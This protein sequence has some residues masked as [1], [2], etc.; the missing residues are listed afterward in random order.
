MRGFDMGMDGSVVIELKLERSRFDRDLRQVE[1]LAPSLQ[2]G[3]KLDAAKFKTDLEALQKNRINLSASVEI[4]TASFAQQVKKLSQSILPIKVDLAPNVDDFQEKLRR[5]SR[6]SPINVEIKADKAAVASEFEQIGKHAASGFAQGF[7]GS[8]NAAESAIDSLVNSVKTQLGIQSPSRVFR[9]IGKYAIEGLMQGLDSVDESKIKGV[10]NEIEGYFKASKI[11][12]EVGLKADTS[13]LSDAIDALTEVKVNLKVDSSELDEVTS[14]IA[15]EVKTK[16]EATVTVQGN[17]ST[18]AAGFESAIAKGMQ[19]ALAQ[20]NKGAKQDGMSQRFVD[21][22]LS[23]INAFYEGLKTVAKGALEKI[24]ASFSQSFGDS[25]SKGLSKDFGGVIQAA[26]A[27][28]GESFGFLGKEITGRTKYKGALSQEAPKTF[29][30]L[31]QGLKPLAS[32]INQIASIFKK[33]GLD[34]GGFATTIQKASASALSLISAF[35]KIESAIGGSKQAGNAPQAATQG[36]L[37]GNVQTLTPVQAKGQVEAARKQLEL[38]LAE[39][40]SLPQ[41]SETRGKI[42]QLIADI[43]KLETQIAS[44]IKNSAIPESVRRSLGKLKGAGGKLAELKTE[45]EKMRLSMGSDS[46]TANRPDVPASR[47]SLNLSR[48]SRSSNSTVSATPIDEDL[49]SATK[50]FQRIFGEIAKLSGIDGDKANIPKLKFGALPEGIAGQYVPGRNQ[51]ALNPDV[52][53]RL[54]SGALTV[55]DINTISHEIRH[56]LQLSFGK[57][58]PESLNL[59]AQA[60]GVALKSVRSGS[61][62]EKDVE[63]SLRAYKEAFKQKFGKYPPRAIVE[64]IRK[65]EADAYAFA[66]SATGE[67]HKNLTSILK[68][69]RPRRG[70]RSP[71]AQETTDNNDLGLF[72]VRSGNPDQQAAENFFRRL[73]ARLYR[74]PM[75]RGVPASERRSMVSEASGFA[76]SGAA[77][78]NPAATIG[79]L[80]T[81]LTVGIMPLIATFGLLGNALKPLI[82][83]VTETLKKLEPATKRLEFVSGSKEAA[84]ADVRFVTNTSD[85]LDIP[86]LA[87]IEGF[88]KLSAAAKGTELEG[89]GVKELF[90]GI[91]TASKALQMSQEDLNGVMYGFTQSLSKQRFT[92]EEVRLQISERMPGAI[93]ALAKALKMSVPEF[94]EALESGKLGIDALAKAGKGLKD[95]YS[96]GAESASGGLLSALTRVDNAILKLQK[97]LAD[98]FGPALAVFNNGF[99]DLI[100]F[101]S[102]NLDNIIKVFNVAVIGIGAQFLV[103]LT[104]ILQGTG[105][106]AKIA[107]FLTPL[108]AR[109]GTTMTP[110]VLG[111]VSDL[112]D[113]V[114]GTK[115]SVMDN[116]MKGFYNMVLSAI[117]VVDGGIKKVKELFNVADEGI[118]KLPRVANKEKPEGNRL[119]DS[120][121]TAVVGALAGGLAGG[122]K[123]GAVGAVAGAIFGAVGGMEALRKIIPSTIIELAALT[124]MLIQS[125]VLFKMSLGPQIAAF[126]GN[127]KAMGAAF[128]E[129]ARTGGTLRSG[130][131]TLTAGLQKTQLAAFAATAA[132]LL[133]FAK[134]DFSNEL[135][136]KFDKLG[137]R[138]AAAMEKAGEA[139]QKVV[140]KQKELGNKT[141]LKSKGFD[142]TLGLGQSFGMENGFRTDDIIKDIQK[143]SF[144]ETFGRYGVV[145]V[146]TKAAGA[147]T[148]A[149]NMFDDN[150]LKIDERKKELGAIAEGSGLLNGQFKTTKA[151]ESLEKSKQIESEIKNLQNRR[152]SLVEVPG[153]TKD[154]AVS[155]QV[156]ELEKQIKDKEKEFKEAV[157]PAQQLRDSI[158]EK[159]KILKEAFQLINE[160]DSLPE[161]SKQKLRDRLQP[162][163]AEADKLKKALTEVGLTDLSP[164]GKQFSEVKSAIEK[165]N[166]E[167]ENGKMLRQVELALGQQADYEDYAAGKITKEQLDGNLK[168]KERK[169]LQK[170]ADILSST[171]GTRKTELRDLL[172]VPSPNKE[173]KEAI[174]KTQKEIRDKEL[175][176]AKTRIQIA[177]NIADAKS[178]AEEDALNAFQEANAK[179][180]SIIQRQQ[181]EQVTGIKSKLMRGKINQEQAD[182]L[183]AENNSNAALGD[184][185]EAKR[186][187]SDF[188]SKRNTLS[189]KVAA[190]QELE[191]QKG[192]ADANLKYIESELSRVELR[193]KQIISD[194][195]LANRKAEATISVT[196]TTS[197]TQIK[198]AQLSGDISPEKAAQLQ[199]QVDQKATASSAADI[200]RRIE[201]NKQLRKDGTRDAKTATEIELQ[202][203]QELAKANQQS[204]D[205]QI[206]AQQ[207]LRDE[208]EKTFQRRKAQLDLEQTTSTTQI[209]KAQLSGDISPE[210]AAQ[211][212]NQID[213]KAAVDNINLIKDKIAKNRQ[214]RA[215]GLLDAQTFSDKETQLNQELASANQSLIDQQIQ[216]Q[217]QLRDAID[218]TFQRRKSQLDLEKSSSDLKLESNNLDQLNERVNSKSPVDLKGL[219][220]SNKA[221]SLKSD[222]AD[223]EK[224]LNLLNDQ[225][226]TIPSQNYSPQEASDKRKQLKTEFNR[227]RIT[228]IKNEQE[229]ILN[230]QEIELNGI[231]RAKQAEENRHKQ[232]ISNLDEQKSRLDLIN[233]S[234]ELTSKLNESRLNLGKALSDA[235][236]SPLEIRKDT[237]NR[238]LELS[239]KLKDENLDPGVREEIK[240][241]LSANGFGDKELEILKQRSQI[242][243]EIAAKKLEALKLEQAYQRKALEL[244]LQ[245]QRIA[246]QMQL[247]E[248]QG[249]QLAAA[250]SSIEANSALRAA[251]VK[252]DDVAIASAK[253]GIELAAKEGDL[254]S[255]KVELA[256]QALNAQTELTQNAKAAQEATQRMAIDQQLAADSARKQANSLEQAEASAKKTS[257]NQSKNNE[258]SASNSVAGWEN[259]FIQKPGEG[260]FAYNLRINKAKAEGRIIET[261]VR[262]S[263][264]DESGFNYDEA[265]NRKQGNPPASDFESKPFKTGT[266]GLKQLLTDTNELPESLRSLVS[267]TSNID[268]SLQL[269]TDKNNP[270]N[271]K[272]DDIAA[273][274]KSA[275][276]ASTPT[277]DTNIATLIIDGFKSAIS[278]VEQRMDSLAAS[279]TALANTPR[280]LTVQSCAPVDDAASILRDIA[281]NSAAAAGI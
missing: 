188:E 56:A 85:K 207:Q 220:L 278:G 26:G 272:T 152:L 3:L 257:S 160:D 5:L 182:K 168:S 264:V 148:V 50:N 135:G 31:E 129:N 22:T 237:A 244:D 36:F 157:K 227:L 141:E 149:E 42:A 84:A 109:V 15:S 128:L 246:A 259:P 68:G 279:I 153:A 213:Q 169:S 189:P 115:T 199:N 209:K 154:P 76:F 240:K 32:E 235:T 138:A 187:I 263:V 37:T 72:R 107:A 98:S 158:L 174:D 159:E 196:Q 102:S 59:K 179:A 35:A 28:V 120:A 198:K 250:K 64:N 112:L 44:D 270:L 212:Q 49:R 146:A 143:K 273:Q 234:L 103:G 96:S 108:L 101:I 166:I 242:E 185:T 45:A 90:E 48:V 236:I 122:A 14:Q 104:V 123:G 20:E 33:T 215:K 225:Y 167:L 224:Q 97:G 254:A 200:K 79:A 245:R 69:N 134:A 163:T 88:S 260:L 119:L 73:E 150:L 171:L 52:K 258:P 265:L 13:D 57:L 10:V 228:Q 124:L 66:E 162:A 92:A 233:Q 100:G 214:E 127:L 206:Q 201:E 11:T 99:A 133:F 161:A 61:E 204:I 8:E 19:S 34:V 186:Q 46:E 81:P 62:L 178:K 38:Q 193:K 77:M 78:L 117:L 140:D 70:R 126:I 184:I 267:N 177:Q 268:K 147:R 218:K 105:I 217:Q 111:I 255:K 116:M 172:A 110:F 7:A 181:T 12:A 281:N 269:G 253:L 226:A 221:N 208:I 67:I 82:D 195:E 43:T 41:S 280:S 40:K 219:E 87:S 271:L 9:E 229:Q 47:T 142:L 132:F 190:K 106:P 4:D 21:F 30:E 114:F 139:T 216:G 231:E 241:Q 256:N 239:R 173:Q 194:L 274:V 18:S 232:L 95:F 113:D 145:G 262:K 80:L 251:E 130:L 54:A 180:A 63:A 151:G 252:K 223:I 276:A 247:Y 125:A 249:A 24:G 155:K 202:L 230:K 144:I 131:S 176:L 51:L 211:Q 27:K 175:E 75:L 17:G 136:S 248:A 192:L 277:P 86:Q 71:S 205:Q 89:E 6:I 197:T 261:N 266:A 93:T 58:R 55:D 83:I 222:R 53:K 165:S 16:V 121:G 203:N 210:Q 191:L 94:N 74:S 118:K 137:D 183:L 23:P 156:Q 65:L 164:L 2:V 243:D 1:N 275:I 60:P 238:S 29:S 170:D 39:L 91:A 25:L